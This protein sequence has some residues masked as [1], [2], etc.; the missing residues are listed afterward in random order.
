M[1]TYTRRHRPGI[2]GVVGAFPYLYILEHMRDQDLV[3]DGDISIR[4][5]GIGDILLDLETGFI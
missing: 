5:Q 4:I 2:S 1:N 3:C